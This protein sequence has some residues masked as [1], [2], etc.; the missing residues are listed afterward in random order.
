MQLLY[1][2]QINAVTAFQNNLPKKDFCGRE[3]VKEE[4]RSW[5]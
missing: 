4:L 1:F 2:K 5:N 3:R